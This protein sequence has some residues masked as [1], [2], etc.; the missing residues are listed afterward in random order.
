MIN[1]LSFVVLLCGVL[2]CGTEPLTQLMLVVDSDIASGSGLDRV[3]VQVRMP[4]GETRS[5][6]FAVTR[7]PVS[8]ALVHRDGPLGPMNVRVVGTGPEG[9]V[10]AL[11]ITEFISGEVRELRVELERACVSEDCGGSPMTC[12]D[13]VCVSA[14]RPGAELPVW[15]GFVDSGTQDA[16]AADAEPDA[17]SD[18]G[19]DSEPD[20]PDDAGEDTAPD[21]ELD[22]PDADAGDGCVF[23]GDESC[24]EVDDDC[25]GR[26]DEGFD[27]D[28][29]EMHCG[30]CMNRCAGDVA[31]GTI[32]CDRGVCVLDCDRDYASCDGDDD[33]G[34]EIDTD[35]NPNH[36]GDC[37]RMC[38]PED[39][40]MGA[41]D[42][43]MC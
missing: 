10:E 23:R 24:N 34:C 31:R 40:E 11:A 7:W 20:A 3:D 32:E 19:A 4:N 27:F 26:V 6:D 15:S 14:V 38:S 42:M 2:G 16:D 13:G 35:E 28:R 33:N 30:R 9:P 5:M 22:A 17:P 36:C 21:A 12:D 1:R 39:M 25:D 41:C 8:L 37:D 18:S 43:G 29:D